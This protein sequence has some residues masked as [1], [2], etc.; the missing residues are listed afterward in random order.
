MFLTCTC[1]GI[2]HTADGSRHALG[3][4]AASLEA[5]LSSDTTAPQAAPVYVCVACYQR[6]DAPE[7]ACPGCGHGSA[8]TQRQELPAG[9]FTWKRPDPTALGVA[10]ALGTNEGCPLRQVT[11]RTRKPCLTNLTRVGVCCWQQN[12]SFMKDGCPDS[13]RCNKALPQA[14]AYTSKPNH[15]CG[16]SHTETPYPRRLV[17]HLGS[18]GRIL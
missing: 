5:S 9:P 2:L 1:A 11:M 15:K 12:Y 8:A 13:G 4:T 14:G 10:C 17:A 6:S 16:R 7:G 3:Q 18:H